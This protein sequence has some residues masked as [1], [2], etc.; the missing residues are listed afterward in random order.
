MPSYE[1]I[2]QTLKKG[3]FTSYLVIKAKSAEAAPRFTHAGTWSPQMEYRPSNEWYAADRDWAARR[4]HHKRSHDRRK[5]WSSRRAA[6]RGLEDRVRVQQLEIRTPRHLT[7][8][9][10]QPSLMNSSVVLETRSRSI[11]FKPPTTAAFFVIESPYRGV[12][13]YAPVR[14]DASQ[15]FRRFFA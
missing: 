11:C 9:Q 15:T 13:Q 7:K 14:A 6:G 5:R 3:G 4:E 10:W 2:E 1:Q 12:P 8:I